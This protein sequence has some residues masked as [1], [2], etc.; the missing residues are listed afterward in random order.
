MSKRVGA[1]YFSPTNTT[2]I[3]CNAIALGMGEKNPKII[4]MTRPDIRKNITSNADILLSDID[5]LIVGSPVYSGKLPVEVIECLKFIEGNGKESTAIFV[6]G[7][8]DYGIALYRM[9]EI[10]FKNGFSVISAGA[11]I[12]QH[13]YSD[14]VPVAMGRPDKSD[15]EKAYNFGNSSL[16]IS[17][18][19]S[20]EKIP[21]QTDIFS[22]SDKYTPLKPVFISELCTQCG[23]CAD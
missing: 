16:N 13:S 18:C 2:K 17:K 4:D 20:L 11:F 5:H 21:I 12:G 7:N 15:M 10:L 1:L 8:R 6:Y 19:L 22:K 3:I 9:V 14:I 23:V